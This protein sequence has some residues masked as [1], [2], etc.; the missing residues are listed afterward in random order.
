MRV[1]VATDGSADAKAA[2]EWVR[3]LPLADD[4]RFLVLSV[5]PRPLVANQADWETTERQVRVHE[6][7]E[8]ID[9]ACRLLGASVASRIAEGDA[10]EEIVATALDWAADL[11]VLGARGLSAVKEF[12][13]GSVSLGVARHAPC[14][15]L[16]CKGSPR[17]VHTI[18]VAHDG[19]PG[20]RAAFTFVTGLP[21]LPATHMRIIGVAEPMRYPPT[22]PEI[23]GGALRAAVADIERERCASL[24]RALA[25]EIAA[26]RARVSTADLTVA[27]GLP[28]PEILR[29]AD[30]TETDVLVVG[31]RGLGTMKRLLLGSVSEAV[32]RHAACPVLVV[33][34]RA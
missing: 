3:R 15:V 32:L 17:S 24:E 12:L 31:A 8:A 14:P 16:V 22:A 21:L 34:G 33:R 10:R 13:L 2:V 23:I 7:H 30:V 5:I 1:M 26:L 25:P 28:A 19:S 29:Y 20:A 9:D 11:I 27:V 18:T 6:A 4:A